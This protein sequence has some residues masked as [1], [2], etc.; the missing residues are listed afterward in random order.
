MKKVKVG[1]I[2]EDFGF[3]NWK[4]TR[5]SFEHCKRIYSKDK[6]VSRNSRVTYIG[7]KTLLEMR[8]PSL[9]CVYFSLSVT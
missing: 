4:L 2:I 1:Y 5:C 8:F 6:R 9:L 3:K 7:L